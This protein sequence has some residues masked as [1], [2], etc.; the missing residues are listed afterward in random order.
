MNWTYSSYCGTIDVHQN[1][2][3]C[4]DRWALRLTLTIIKIRGI[5]VV[6]LVANQIIVCS[7]YFILLSRV[8]SVI[9]IKKLI[10]FLYQFLET[11]N[12]IFPLSFGADLIFLPFNGGSSFICRLHRRNNGAMHIH[13]SL[14][15]NIQPLNAIL[16]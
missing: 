14:H 5:I 7:T 13:T 8:H 9:V 3:F 4:M 15:E 12:L 2:F 10:D 16:F 11:I 1:I 6:W